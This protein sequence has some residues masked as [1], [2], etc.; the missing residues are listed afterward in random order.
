MR[1]C[2]ALDPVEKAN[3]RNVAN[4]PL[5]GGRGRRV[6][7]ITMENL[8]EPER[9]NEIRAGQYYFC[10]SPDCP[11]VYFNNESGSIFSK[12]SLRVRVGIKEK[13]DPIPLCYCF[14]Y[15]DE[16]IRREVAEKGRSAIPETIRAEV[17]AGNC[18]CEITNP[19]GS[20][21]L[22]TVDA[23][24]RRALKQRHVGVVTNGR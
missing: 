1:D 14:G 11:A 17:K 6:K 24:V 20:C 22:G 8:L 2:C 13:S 12:E 10:Q 23:A 9:L 21:C 7:R 16:M 4:C 18:S 15:T 3:P 19:S 5:C